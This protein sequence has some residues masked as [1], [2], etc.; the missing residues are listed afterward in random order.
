MAGNSSQGSSA[1]LNGTGPQLSVF[2][3][4]LKWYYV[5]DGLLSG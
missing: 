4:I 5:V 3:Y 1:A 2:E